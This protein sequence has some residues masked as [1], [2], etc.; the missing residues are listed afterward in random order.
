MRRSRC[1]RSSFFRKFY[2][3]GRED[4]LV[5]FFVFCDV[6]I[7]VEENLVELFIGIWGFVFCN[8]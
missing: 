7:G 5:S 3:V 1:G 4:E 2:E 8:E 6:S